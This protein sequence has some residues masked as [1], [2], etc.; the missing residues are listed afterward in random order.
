MA[1][2][3]ENSLHVAQTEPEGM[4]PT[5]SA[6]GSWKWSVDP[7]E[8]WDGECTRMT[9]YDTSTCVSNEVFS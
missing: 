1:R 5:S 9:L 8:H 6:V 2:R 4:F 7:G 3:C